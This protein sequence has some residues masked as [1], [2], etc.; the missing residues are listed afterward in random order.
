MTVQARRRLRVPADLA[1]LAEIRT[2][3]REVGVSCGAPSVCLDD[4]VQAV[5]EA[6]TNIVVHG[7]RGAPGALDIGAE[8]V[9]DSIVI[10]LEDTAP[11]FDPTSVPEPD[12]L[13]PPESRQPGGM[14]IHLMR[15]AMDS[16]GHASRPGGGNI[17]TM[18]RR[19]DAPAKEDR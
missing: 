16:V 17:L 13:M 11:S 14:G 15:L 18:T 4:I 2:L 1:R 9:G 8:L 3:V 6:A 19:L 10:T 12:L 7:Y 5:D